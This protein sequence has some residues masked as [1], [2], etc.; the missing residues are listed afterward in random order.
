LFR[1]FAHRRRDFRSYRPT[2]HDP[3][4]GLPEPLTGCAWVG[5]ASATIL[6]EYNKIPMSSVRFTDDR[7]VKRLRW[8]MLGVML[9]SVINTLIGQP[10][11]FWYAPESAI[12]GDGLS[13]HNSTNPTFEFFLGHG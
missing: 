10:K 3:V 4:F 12:R 7:I 6:P 5:E 8:I 2:G 1:L 13:I 9:F 11:S